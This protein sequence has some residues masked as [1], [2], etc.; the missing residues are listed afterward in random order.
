M[1]LSS[2]M[3]KTII[4]PET[5]LTHR[6][7]TILFSIV[8]EYCDHGEIMSSSILKEKYGFPFSAATIR[9]EMVILRDLGYLYQ[10]FTNSSSRPTEHSFKMFINQLIVGLQV[11]NK[12]QN[13]LKRQISEMEKKQS[14]LSKEISRLLAL[15]SGGVGFMVNQSSESISGM[16]NLLTD[17]GGE[18]QKVSDILD[19]LD[20]LDQHKQLLL[21]DGESENGLL[22]LKP[23]ERK[24]LKTMIGDDNPVLKLGKGYGMVSTEVYLENGEKTVVGLITPLHLLARKKNLE[25]IDAISKLFHENGNEH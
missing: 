20:N 3:P 24:R 16:G 25:L 1:L 4:D 13:E 6:Q 5:Q 11:T 2:S 7:K 17:S 14:N 8:K 22:A 9:N 10:P 23:S 18:T 19:F 15:T 12:Q 21:M